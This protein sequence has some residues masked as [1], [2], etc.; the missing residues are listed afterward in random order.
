V[1][2]LIREH[3]TIHVAERPITDRQQNRIARAL[4]DAYG[5]RIAP[6]E[7]AFGTIHLNVLEPVTTNEEAWVLAA[8]RAET[9][10]PMAWHPADS[11]GE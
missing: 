5:V 3:Q 10:M 8:F 9:D 4:K 7:D 6:E 1:K 2:L 11:G